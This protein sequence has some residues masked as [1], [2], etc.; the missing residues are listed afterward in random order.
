MFVETA[1]VPGKGKII[2]TGKLGEVMQ[3]S[4]QAALT[5][6]KSHAKELK[7]DSKQFDETNVHIHVPEGAISKDGPSAG[8]ALATAITSAFTKKPVPKGLAMTGEITLRGRVLRIGGLKEKAI[9]AH[10][11]G[12]SKVIIPGEN[13]RDLETLP[14]EV[15]KD[16]EFIPVSE[17]S[18]V[19]EIAFKK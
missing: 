13:E 5:F 3:E 15:K 19:L 17:A 16:I 7:I 6:V 14:K 10:L 18:K 8:I 11:A 1:L 9:A 4:A 12:L 2:L